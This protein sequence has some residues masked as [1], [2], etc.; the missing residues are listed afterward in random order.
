MKKL[1]LLLLT[2]LAIANFHCAFDSGEDDAVVSQKA[3]NVRDLTPVLPQYIVAPDSTQMRYAATAPE[4]KAVQPGDIVVS[5]TNGNSPVGYLKKVT[6]VDQVAGQTVITAQPA[7]ITEAVVNGEAA[8]SGILNPAGDNSLMNGATYNP[9]TGLIEQINPA[10]GITVYG[11]RQPPNAIPECKTKRWYVEFN[12]VNIQNA[13]NINGCVGMDLQFVLN[14]KIKWFELKNA[15]FSVAPSL[16][17]KL[18]VNLNGAT[19]SINRAQVTLT[20][21]YLQPI[22]F[23][24]G[25]VPVVIVPRIAIVLGVDGK[26]TASLTTSLQYSASAKAGISYANKTWTPIKTHTSTYNLVPPVF[27]GNVDAMVYAGPEAAFLLYGVAGPTANVYIYSHFNVAWNPGVGQPN[28][29]DIWLGVQAGAGFTVEVFGRTLVKIN[30]PAIIG[31]EALIAS[32]KF[33]GIA[34]LGTGRVTG[35]I[36]DMINGSYQV[37]S[38]SQF[39]TQ[40]MSG[41]LVTVGNIVGSLASK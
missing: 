25:F 26:I 35:T 3:D 31:Y 7:T 20:T 30:N 2:T 10:P 24:I 28:S 9:A 37:P 17:T 29:W 18:G 15:E 16:V 12:N 34:P 38:G 14:M 8:A 33:G 13:G 23:V 41:D 1:T 27:S 4:V 40:Y 22:T 5:D 36:G 32:S 11:T 19:F 6:A 39:V 21:F